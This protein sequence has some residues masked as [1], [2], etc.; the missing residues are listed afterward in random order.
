[1]SF[2]LAE[3]Y[4][5]ERGFGDRILTFSVSSATV[6]LAA[7]ALGTEPARIAKSLTFSV[8]GKPVMILCAGD[9]KIANPKYKA[10]FRVKAKM[11]S[12]E[13]VSELIG[14]EVGGVCPFGIKE[15]VAVY[16][17][18]SLKRFD[19]VYPA[20]GNAASAVRLSVAELE[21]LAGPVSW[22]DVCS[23]D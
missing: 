4:L 6:E 7:E 23:W 13:E 12:R 18:E 20:C 3:N 9:A 11:L 8:D 16:L 19:T 10:Q 1:M 22:V 5:K 14:H 2:E 21:K 17:D 15:D